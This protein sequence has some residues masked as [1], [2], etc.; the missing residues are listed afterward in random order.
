MPD[1]LK[2]KLQGSETDRIINEA[3][4]DY[5]ENSASLFWSLLVP[6]DQ[7]PANPRMLGDKVGFCLEKITD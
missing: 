7:S 4:L 1:S 6:V 3:H 5:D 2:P